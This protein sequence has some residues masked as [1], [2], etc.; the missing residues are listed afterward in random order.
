MASPNIPP[1][2]YFYTTGPQVGFDLTNYLVVNGGGNVLQVR[3]SGANS[4]DRPGLQGRLYPSILSAAAQCRANAGDVI[5][6]LEGHVETISTANYL[7][8]LPAGV[9]ILGNGRGTAQ[10]KINFTAA[11]AT[12]WTTAPANTVLAGFNINMNATAAILVAAPFTI[13]AA[14]C[15]VIN[16]R[17]TFSTSATQQATAPFT[18]ATGGDRFAFVG[19]E[20]YACDGSFATNPTNG[21]LVSGAVAGFNCSY[22]KMT[23]ATNATGTGVVQFSAAATDSLIMWNQFTNNKASSTAALVGFAGVTGTVDNNVLTILAAS[24]AITAIATP[25]NWTMGKGNSAV[26]QGSAGRL[27]IAVGTASS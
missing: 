16:N 23:M 21:I 22:N 3:S 17:M 10:A 7:G 24:G 20:F 25:G 27:G 2:Q 4:G 6:V 12:M 13:N 1:L 19:N 5:E 14:D 8:A 11:A 15:A 9:A 18:V 26:A